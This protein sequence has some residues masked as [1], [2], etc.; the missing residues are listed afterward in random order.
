MTAYQADLISSDTHGA[1]RFRHT[2]SQPSHQVPIY[3]RFLLN[4]PHFRVCFPGGYH[5]QYCVV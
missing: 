3:G 2:K 4:D 5:L 1:C